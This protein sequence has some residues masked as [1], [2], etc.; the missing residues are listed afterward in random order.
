MLQK[1]AIPYWL[2]KNQLDSVEYLNGIRKAVYLMKSTAENGRYRFG[3]IGAVNRKANTPIRRLGQCTHVQTASILSAWTYVAMLRLDDM[4]TPKN[5]REL[6]KLVRDHLFKNDGLYAVNRVS[7]K[8]A[9]QS[10]NDEDSL[11]NSF[12]SSLTSIDLWSSKN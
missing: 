5:V 6:E 2:N 10:C 8:D 7:K 12:K 9:L 3:G 11:I 1:K 4:T